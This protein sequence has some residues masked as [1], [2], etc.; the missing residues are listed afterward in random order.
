MSS[1]C[2]VGHAPLPSA[3]A[4]SGV[5]TPCRH[6]VY[7]AS[8]ASPASLDSPVAG[9]KS[10]AKVGVNDSGIS[11]GQASSHSASSHS[12]ASGDGADKRDSLSSNPGAGGADADADRRPADAVHGLHLPAAAGVPYF[13]AGADEDDEMMMVT[14]S[15]PYSLNL[16]LTLLKLNLTSSELSYHFGIVTKPNLT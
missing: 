12:S 14:R 9:A 11:P 16:D 10:G 7:A 5:A 13:H 4:T 6:D 15:H 3:A 2:T 1:A 8:V